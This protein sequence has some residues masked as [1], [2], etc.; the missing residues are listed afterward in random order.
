MARRVVWSREAKQDLADIY[1]YIK[2]DNPK[3]AKTVV[4]RIRS[5]TKLLPEHPWIGRVV[6]EHGRED[7]RER[8]YSRYR[9]FYQISGEDQIRILHI[10]HSAQEELPDL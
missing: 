6:P 4:D 10:F 9:L 5:L 2:T 1:Q 7:I 3:A 8:I